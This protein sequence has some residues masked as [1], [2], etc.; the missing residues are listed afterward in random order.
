MKSK[1]Q[2]VQG[3]LFMLVGCVAYALSTVLFL[4]PNEIVAGGVTG[5]SVLINILNENIPIGMISIALNIPILLLAIKFCGIKFVLRCLLTITTLGILTDLLMF[6]PDITDDAILASLYGGICQGIGI[7]CF[8]KYEFSS[9]GTELLGRLVSRWTKVLKIPICVGILDGIIV[10]LGAIVTQNFNNMLYALIVIFVSTKLSELVLMGIEKSKF[11]IIITDRGRELSKALI[12]RSPRGITMLEGEGM[13][14][15]QSHN[16][17]MTCVKNR[18]LTELK[19]IVKSVDPT[20]F[21]IVND[22]VE[23]RGKGFRELSEH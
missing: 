23:V 13:Y 15:S 17:L 1:L 8:V 19:A 3:Y 21:I 4:S 16:V 20:A 11:C 18:Q 2:S 22:S 7:G 9:G 6:L 12:Q 14:T 10:V 5:L